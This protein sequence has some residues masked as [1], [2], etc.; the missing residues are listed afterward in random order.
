LAFIVTVA[1]LHIGNNLAVPV[2][3]FGAKSYSCSAAS[4]TP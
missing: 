1:V 3:L 2:S 4:R